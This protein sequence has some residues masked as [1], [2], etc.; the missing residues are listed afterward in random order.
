[1]YLVFLLT[2]CVVSSFLTPAFRVSNTFSLGSKLVSTRKWSADANVGKN[3]GGI[4]EYRSDDGSPPPELAALFGLSV[5]E[6]S[7]D[8]DEDQ[9]GNYNFRR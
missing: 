9:F 1:M 5:E 7:Q 3:V 6:T 8:K 4:Y 2:L